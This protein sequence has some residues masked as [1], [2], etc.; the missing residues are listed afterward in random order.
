MTTGDAEE[1][2]VGVVGVDFEEGVGE[3][4]TES[5]LYL[6]IMRDAFKNKDDNMSE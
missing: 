3:T 4:S 6:K 5:T 1:V 2:G